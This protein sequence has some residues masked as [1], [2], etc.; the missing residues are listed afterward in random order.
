MNPKFRLIDIAKKANVS[1][2]TVDRVVNKR[3]KVAPKTEKLILEIINEFD[4]QPN[5]MAS[6]L[7]SKKKINFAV[8]VPKPQ[9]E[10]YWS[11]IFSGIES[12]EKTVREL[13]VVISKFLYDQDDDLQ[14]TELAAKI[15][16]SKYDGV[17][18]APRFHKE[19]QAFAQSLESENIPYLFIDTIIEDTHPICSI[20]QNDFQS[21]AL[22]AKLIDYGIESGEEILSISNLTNTDNFDLMQERSKGFKSFFENPMNEKRIIHSLEIVN[23]KFQN[24]AFLLDEKLVQCPNIKGIFIN[25]SKAHMVARYLSE[26][27]ILKI[28]L[29]GF[30]LIEQNVKYLKNGFIDFILFDYAENQGETGLQILFDYIMKKKKP[31]SKINMPIHIVAKENLEGF[32]S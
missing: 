21:G 3:G 28:K 8:L 13:G 4:Y 1:L 7:S 22:A 27:N 25:N 17:L 20:S 31:A 10:D 16:E 9:G 32:L 29:V 18:V 6:S 19:A 14:F 24:L 30:D 11:K 15:L 26:N 12:A 2:G 5:L 23:L